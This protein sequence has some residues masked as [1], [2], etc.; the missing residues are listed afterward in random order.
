MMF[1]R[2]ERKSRDP[3][4]EAEQV[5]ATFVSLLGKLMAPERTKARAARPA[6][7]EVI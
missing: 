6:A 4:A 5:L 3:G 7:P 1:R 2:K